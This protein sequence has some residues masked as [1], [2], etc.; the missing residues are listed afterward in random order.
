[1]KLLIAGEGKDELGR[2]AREKSYQTLEESS[3]GLIEALLRRVRPDGWEIVEGWMWKL[4]PKYQARRGRPDPTREE[5]R[6]EGLGPEGKTL[7]GL[8]LLAEERGCDAL[9]FA[10]DRDGDEDREREI[11]D[12][13]KLA[14]ERF[15]TRIAGSVAVEEIESW[16]LSMLSERRA[17]EHADPK[18]VL[19]D[20]HGI[21][22]LEQKVRVVEDADIDR[23]RSDAHSLRRWI[24][25]VRELG[26]DSLGAG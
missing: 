7:L 23:I 25:R 26:E 16:L 9:V 20:R 4:I 24:E 15:T 12:A 6:R 22:T 3:P 1:M 18:Q 10:R 21:A 19:V 8:A 11:D 5:V 14:K 2:W 17:E 13:L